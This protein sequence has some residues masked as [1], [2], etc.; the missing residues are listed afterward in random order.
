MVSEVTRQLHKITDIICTYLFSVSKE[1]KY[2]CAYLK[3][4]FYVVMSFDYTASTL[5]NQYNRELT[6]VDI[7][8]RCKM[9]QQFLQYSN[10]KSTDINVPF[11]ENVVNFCISFFAIILLNQN[12]KY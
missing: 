2:T 1:M 5:S 10:L 11:A 8:Q 7:K 4:G 6:R 12:R 3:T 9:N